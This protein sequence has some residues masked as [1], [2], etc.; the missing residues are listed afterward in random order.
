MSQARY[1]VNIQSISLY[2]FYADIFRLCS[3]SFSFSRF[4]S[5]SIINNFLMANVFV[6]ALWK[7]IGILNGVFNEKFGGSRVYRK[8]S[9][10]VWDRGAGDSFFIHLAAILYWNYF[11]FRP[12]QPIL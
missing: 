7:E 2:I 5:Y 8:R 3:I 11:R 6:Q 4:H 12:V 10:R 1:L 9:V